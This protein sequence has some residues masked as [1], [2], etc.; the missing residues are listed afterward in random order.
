[1]HTTHCVCTASTDASSITAHGMQDGTTQA[2]A[3]A[4]IVTCSNVSGLT[5]PFDVGP[6]DNSLQIGAY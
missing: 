2:V 5:P 1:M 6:H 4:V 3:Y